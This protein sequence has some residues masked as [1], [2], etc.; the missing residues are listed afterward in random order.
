MVADAGA[1]AEDVE[2]VA[3]AVAVMAEAGAVAAVAAVGVGGVAAVVPDA[4]AGTIMV[5]RQIMAATMAITTTMTNTP[6]PFTLTIIRSRMRP[7]SP[8]ILHPSRLF[9]MAASCPR[10]TYHR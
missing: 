10:A 6:I 5:G 3:V 7:T 1:E 9:P 8:F 4:G 2:T